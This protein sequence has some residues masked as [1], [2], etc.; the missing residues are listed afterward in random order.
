MLSKLRGILLTQYIGAMVTALVAAQCV[1]TLLSLIL[2]FI[3]RLVAVW[4]TPTSLMGES[5][6]QD[7]DWSRTI[8]SFIDVLLYAV[9]VYGLIRWL[10]FGQ[11]DDALR[12]GAETP[13]LAPEPPSQSP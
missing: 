9:V 11:Q 8:Y 2:S 7:F 4:Q 12:E 6:Y 10:Y 1:Q 5:R 13:A 3:W